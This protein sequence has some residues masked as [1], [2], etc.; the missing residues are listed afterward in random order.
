[1]IGLDL[2]GA[3]SENSI[4]HWTFLMYNVDQNVAQSTQMDRPDSPVNS[5]E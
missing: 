1:M 2:V 4:G 5:Q 3:A